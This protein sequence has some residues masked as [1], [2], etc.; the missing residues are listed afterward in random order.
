M[1]QVCILT[2]IVIVF[3]MLSHTDYTKDERSKV[4]SRIYDETIREY[5]HERGILTSIL[6]SLIDPDQISVVMKNIEVLDRHYFDQVDRIA[7][8][9]S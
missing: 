3:C 5:L 6:E 2:T 9:C 1:I 8:M 7:S 4:C